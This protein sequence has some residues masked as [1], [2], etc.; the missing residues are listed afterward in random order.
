MGAVWGFSLGE[1]TFGNVQGHSGRTLSRQAVRMDV[2][3]AVAELIKKAKNR[4]PATSESR[5][6]PRRY[7]FKAYF[8]PE[9]KFDKIY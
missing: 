9:N 6:W 4:E 2:T 7:V 8:S 5:G 3:S 1:S